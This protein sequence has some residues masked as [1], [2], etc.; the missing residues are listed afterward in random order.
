M[1]DFLAELIEIPGVSGYEEK[2]AARIADE[3]AR[4]CDRVR[5]D[6][7]TTYMQSNGYSCPGQPG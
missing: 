5:T 3:F 7:F 4:H 6:E 2:A 1:K